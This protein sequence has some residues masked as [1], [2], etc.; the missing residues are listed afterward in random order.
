MI[1]KPMGESLGIL[2]PHPWL[3]PSHNHNEGHQRRHPDQI[4][5]GLGSGQA[6]QQLAAGMGGSA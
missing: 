1:L 3:Y 4:L 2:N 5:G 6:C